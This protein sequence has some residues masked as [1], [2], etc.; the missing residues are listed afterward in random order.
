MC[1]CFVKIDVICSNNNSNNNNNHNESRDG[2]DRVPSLIFL[3]QD[4][5]ET[6]Q[7]SKLSHFGI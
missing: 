2:E 3:F 4:Y 6:T 1:L 5:Y 7:E